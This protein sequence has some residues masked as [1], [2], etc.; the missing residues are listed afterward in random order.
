MPTVP[1]PIRR[2]SSLINSTEVDNRDEFVPTS[3][4]KDA[5]YFQ[6][7]LPDIGRRI[8][9]ETW[10]PPS[11]PRSDND[12]YTKVFAGEE[13]R[14]DLIALR[15][16]RLEGLWWVIAFAN[17]II[18]PFEEVTVNREL[19]YPPFDTVATTILS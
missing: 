1:V 19:R 10:T 16:Y 13:G 15:V 8:E 9:P 3:R 17:D 11:I 4:Y 2:R 6:R 7:T 14:L 18:D 12:L 5:R